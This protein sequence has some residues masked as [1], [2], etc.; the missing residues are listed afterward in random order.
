MKGG[1]HS[2]EKSKRHGKNTYIRVIKHKQD[3]D[4]P[5]HEEEDE[6]K[7][8][9]S[10]QEEEEEEEEKESPVRKRINQIKSYWAKQKG[11]NQNFK[12]YL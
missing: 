10:S 5:I 9:Y 1:I 6:R 11:R 7:E 12:T 3:I 2:L 4:E 8:T